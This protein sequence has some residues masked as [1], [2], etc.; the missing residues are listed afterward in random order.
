MI[1]VVKESYQDQ[2]HHLDLEVAERPVFHWSSYHLDPFPELTDELSHVSHSLGLWAAGERFS[3]LIGCSRHFLNA[4]LLYR[5]RLKLFY[6]FYDIEFLRFVENSL[7]L[8]NIFGFRKWSKYKL[9]Q[10]TLKWR[11]RTMK[12]SD[13]FK[14]QMLSS[15]CF[16]N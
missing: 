13:W 9:S 3:S 5:A 6:L 12:D 2:K 10:R 11:H 8:S 16:K 4:L 1:V 15:E 7:Y 14:T